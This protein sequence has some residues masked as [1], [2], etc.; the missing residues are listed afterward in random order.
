MQKICNS[1]GHLCLYYA[2]WLGLK[3][4][5][6]HSTVGLALALG[7]LSVIEVICLYGAVIE[8]WNS[9]KVALGFVEEEEPEEM[10]PQQ[11]FDMCVN[12]IREQGR[13]SLSENGTPKYR[14]EGGCKCPAGFIIPDSDYKPEMEGLNFNRVVAKFNLLCR[15][16]VPLIAAI[17]AAHDVAY[18][19]SWNTGIERRPC[20]LFDKVGVLAA[21]PEATQE[22][23][24]EEAFGNVA[25][26][27]NL[28]YE[29]KPWRKLAA[30]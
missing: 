12:G 30:A 15:H 20:Y 26:T 25:R 5:E 22:A 4:P 29:R 3:L 2:L 23:L 24:V 13:R 6:G 21:L 7:T 14:S 17:Q 1:V 27:W 28:Q 10:S 16:S 19:S 11:V 8:W 9:R 18:P